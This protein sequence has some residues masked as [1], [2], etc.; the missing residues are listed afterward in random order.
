MSPVCDTIWSVSANEKRA[1]RGRIEKETG[2][3]LEP[4]GKRLAHRLGAGRS[5]EDPHVLPAPET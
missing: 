5:I 1:A 2:G 4:A 3:L